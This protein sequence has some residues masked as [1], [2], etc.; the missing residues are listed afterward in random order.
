MEQ[1]YKEYAEKN[2]IK[3]T[4]EEFISLV[5]FL[6]TGYYSG[7]LVQIGDELA[8]NFD[9]LREA[10]VAALDLLTMGV[11]IT[12]F[13][14][15][16]S[17][18]TLTMEAPAGVTVSVNGTALTPT[19]GKLVATI[20]LSKGSIATISATNGSK[21]V[22]G[23][24][25]LGTSYQEI[26]ADM[27]GKYLNVGGNTAQLV[28]SGTAS[29][30]DAYR[31]NLKVGTQDLIFNLSKLDIDSISQSLW[32]DI[33]N[34]SDRTLEFTVRVKK[35][36]GNYNKVYEGIHL[37]EAVT[38][39]LKPGMNH[40][41]INGYALVCGDSI[42]KKTASPD[43]LKLTVSDVPSGVKLEITNMYVEKG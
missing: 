26:G 23:N 39:T 17:I 33:Y 27:I 15:G 5:E 43:S 12:D 6:A 41:E 4:D 29:G 31:V 18:I 11:R 34:D 10:L 36:N 40:V 24:Y 25:W 32:L 37:E 30:K 21:T 42:P 19:N 8:S 13:E 20:D 38:I 7:T 16:S 22:S 28:T 2:N 35:G 1:I 14:K 9:T 3:Y